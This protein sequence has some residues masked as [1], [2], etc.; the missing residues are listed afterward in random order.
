MVLFNNSELHNCAKITFTDVLYMS[1]MDANVCIEGRNRNAPC[2]LSPKMHFGGGFA[3]VWDG[4][5]M[6]AKRTST[7][8]AALPLKPKPTLRLF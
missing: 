4:I 1:Q 6:E 3:G 8:L 5:S 2:N 7:G